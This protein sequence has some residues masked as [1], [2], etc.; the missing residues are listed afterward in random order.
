M[1]IKAGIREVPGRYTIERFWRYLWVRNFSVPKPLLQHGFQ[2]KFRPGGEGSFIKAAPAVTGEAFY[3]GDF[4]GRFHARDALDANQVWTFQ[5]DG[6]ITSPPIVAGDTIF[7]G[8]ESGSLYSLDRAGGSLLWRL[9]MGAP[10]AL[11]P[12][13]AGGVLYVRTEDGKLHAVR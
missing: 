9:D 12:S 1:A 8:A 3:A 13:L 10:I 6:P 11:A 5:A 4:N 7:F 2:W